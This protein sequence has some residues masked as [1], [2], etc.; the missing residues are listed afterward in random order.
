MQHLGTPWPVGLAGRVSH[1]C[2]TTCPASNPE[3]AHPQPRGSHWRVLNV[4][5]PWFSHFWMDVEVRNGPD[6]MMTLLW[7]NAH[8]GLRWHLVH[9]TLRKTCCQLQGPHWD[10]PW[11]PTSQ[12]PPALPATRRPFLLPFLTLPRLST[13]CPLQTLSGLLKVDKENCESLSH[14]QFHVTPWTVAHQAPLVMEFFRQNAGV[15]SPSL[16]QGIFPTQGLNPGV[17]LCRQILYHL[18]HRGSPGLMNDVSTK[19]VSLPSF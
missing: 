11:A 18:S 9:V 13:D 10:P 3:P 14:V 12:T 2:Q 16:L 17:P 15:G 1:H 5:G 19:K 4:S 8:E 7:E 6:A